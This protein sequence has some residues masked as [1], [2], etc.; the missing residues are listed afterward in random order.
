MPD[1]YAK[2]TPGANKSPIYSGKEFIERD[3]GRLIQL[4]GTLLD[5]LSTTTWDKATKYEWRYL[6]D[7]YY[8]VTPRKL[9][10]ERFITCGT[11]P[12]WDV[13]AQRWEPRDF[14]QPLTDNRWAGH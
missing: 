1:K 13:E 3:T 14:F 8:R 2:F 5:D 9:F 7:S 4:A 10:V 12:V 11:S 6:S